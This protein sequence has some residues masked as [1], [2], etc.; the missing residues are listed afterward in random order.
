MSLAKKAVQGGLYLTIN[1]FVLFVL[2][3]VS[4]IILARLLIPEHYGIFALGLF[5]FDIVQRIRLFGFKSA[6]IHKKEPSPDEISTHFLLHFIFSVVV[7][8]VS[9]LVSPLISIKY[10]RA[11][12]DVF[13]VLALISLFDNEGLGATPSAL[14][15]KELRYRE[16]SLINFL[17][18]FLSAFAAIVSALAGMGVWSL[19]IQR[20]TFN[21]VLF[22][23]CWLVSPWKLSLR[24]IR[25]NRGAA[26]WFLREQGVF[27]WIVGLMGYVVLSFDDFLVGTLVGVTALGFYS[28]AYNISKMPL[29]FLSNFIQVAFPTYS[30]LQ[31]DKERLSFA[32]DLT[33]GFL[34]RFGFLASIMLLFVAKEAVILLL[35]EKWLPSVI[36][37]QLLVLYSLMRPLQDAMGSVSTALG[38]VREY[39]HLSILQ[40]ILMF[41]L[42]P[43]MTYF[44][45]A[46]G[47]AISVGLI[48]LLGVVLLQR[49]LRERIE[50]NNFR[51]YLYPGVAAL[52]S[53]LAYLG[54]FLNYEFTLNLWF[55]LF[56]KIGLLLLVYLSVLF[57][58][59]GR[60][61]VAR[62]RY[63]LSVVYG[64]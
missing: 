62:F 52:A 50:I 61:L 6:L 16:F 20:A 34:V 42:T 51:I 10:D 12:V 56:S 25:L 18:F 26:R 39:S 9:L 19:V 47:A 64:K 32:Y 54:V 49:S 33:N 2:G 37:I 28:M 48:V 44:Y 55:V 29:G 23:G 15:E 45:Q 14:L 3:F 5:F 63:L 46:K 41:T 27:L 11:I 43:V 22:I 53:S 1:Y 38:K 40:G 59:E 58:L 21:L 8:L 31:D 13:L 24:K 30:K 57:L 36:L 60:V 17:A 4:N 7:I 35:G